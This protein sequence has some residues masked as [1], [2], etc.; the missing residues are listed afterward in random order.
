[1]S[2]RPVF[3]A[4]NQSGTL[5]PTEPIHKKALNSKLRE[6]CDLVGL[7]RR[8]TIYSFRRGAI[9]D[10]R[11]KRSTEA[12]QAI[13]KHVMDSNTIIHYDDNLT[14]QDLA[15][16]RH[17]SDATDRDVIREIFSQATFMRVVLN[18]DNVANMMGANLGEDQGTLMTREANNRAKNDTQILDINDALT[19]ALSDGKQL[20]I[21]RGVDRDLMTNKLDIIDQLTSSAAI[22]DAECRHAMTKIDAI[23]LEKRDLLRVLRRAAGVAIK[24]EWAK[25]AEKSQRLASGTNRAGSR[26]QIT[27]QERM[28]IRESGSTNPFDSTVDQIHRWDPA[29]DP[30]DDDEPEDEEVANDEDGPLDHLNGNTEITFAASQGD[31]PGPTASGRLQFAEKFLGTKSTKNS[32]LECVLCLEDPSVPFD[33]KKAGIL[34]REVGPTPHGKLPL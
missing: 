34:S 5:N 31:A 23:K 1:V 9:V 10:Q 29:A 22:G 26:G 30:N 12:A 3:L 19:A 8:N 18:E 15:N 21:A 13:A 32:G 33:K 20:I 16:I 6:M 4:S 17:G 7:Y 28:T 27:Q 11:R 2:D 14:D 25:E 24:K